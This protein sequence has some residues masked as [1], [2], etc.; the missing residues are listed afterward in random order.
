MSVKNGRSGEAPARA[1]ENGIAHNC[2]VSIGNKTF[3]S[4]FGGF[5]LIEKRIA[6][7][8]N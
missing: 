7:S 5:F 1:P 4:M 2:Y 6:E 3:L 8:V